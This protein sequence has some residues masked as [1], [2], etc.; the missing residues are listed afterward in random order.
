LAR[1]E[2][3]TEVAENETLVSYGSNT[4][5]VLATLDLTDQYILIRRRWDM[6]S[7]F[8]QIVTMRFYR[9]AMGKSR[10]K[11][12]S[13]SSCVNLLAMD[14]DR[15]MRLVRYACALPSITNVLK[16]KIQ[17]RRFDPLMPHTNCSV[18]FRWLRRP[19]LAPTVFTLS[20]GDDQGHSV[21]E[22]RAR[23]MLSRMI[24]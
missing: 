13:L 1:A 12:P 8:S 5:A 14:R 3:L 11:I 21:S 10:K 19:V 22:Y 2:G 24:Q 23:V 17:R 18:R 9:V 20:S 7:P 15:V 6:T 4:W 16:R